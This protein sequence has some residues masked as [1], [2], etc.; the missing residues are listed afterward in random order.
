VIVSLITPIALYGWHLKV[1]HRGRLLLWNSYML[2]KF[3][4][5]TNST[6]ILIL[7]CLRF[8]L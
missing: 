7:A 5:Q 6:M 3:F 4:T 2:V 1:V 8:T